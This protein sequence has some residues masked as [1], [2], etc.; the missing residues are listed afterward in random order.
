ALEGGDF[1]L[2]LM[3]CQMPELD[4]YETT[5]RIRERGLGGGQIPIIAVTAHAVAGDRQR[6]LDAGMNDYISKPYDS[7]GLEKTIRRWL[8]VDDHRASGARAA[9][10]ETT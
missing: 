7:R 4:G 8:W 6:S 10:R 5:R 9:L 3:D 1:D 2:V